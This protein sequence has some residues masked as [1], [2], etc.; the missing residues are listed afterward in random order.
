M[1]TR[2]LGPHLDELLLAWRSLGADERR[3]VVE[4]ARRLAAG[5]ATY[6]ELEL[7]TDRRDLESE[8]GEELLDACVY[9]AAHAIRRSSR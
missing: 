3:V 6:G 7:A 2:A 8:A 9:L 1:K 5:R 4:V